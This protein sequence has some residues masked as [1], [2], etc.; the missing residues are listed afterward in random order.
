MEGENW[1]TNEELNRLLK[2]YT[3]NS[4]GSDNQLCEQDIK[5]LKEMLSGENLQ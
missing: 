3:D 1:L 2:C 4:G 5:K